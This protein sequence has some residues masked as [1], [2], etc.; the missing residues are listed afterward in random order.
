MAYSIY[1]D[2][3]PRVLSLS[4]EPLHPWLKDWFDSVPARKKQALQSESVFVWVKPRMELERWLPFEEMLLWAK[5]LD[6][7]L[8]I[9]QDD[10]LE[11]AK[12]F[13]WFERMGHEDLQPFL[14]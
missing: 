14:V 12:E 13:N 9:S 11:T 3:D 2:L 5:S 7:L 10:L 1:A 4:D 6:L 8:S